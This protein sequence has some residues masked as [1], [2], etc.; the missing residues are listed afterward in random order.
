VGGNDI[1][2]LTFTDNT[3]PI[4]YGDAGTMTGHAT[5]G[6]DTITAE[7]S[8]S[9][10]V[11]T[12]GDAESMSDDT[13]G[14]G[15]TIRIDGIF[16]SDTYGD[17]GQMSGNARGG[18]DKITVEVS[19]HAL[20]SGDGGVLSGNARGGDDTITILSTTGQGGEVDDPSGAT[21]VY[22]D[23]VTMTGQTQGGKDRLIGGHGDEDFW[24]D[25]AIKAATAI[26]GRDTFVFGA[27]SGHD[28]VHDFQ[29]GKDHIE[30]GGIAADSFDELS[31]TEMLIDGKS[32]SVIDLG[33][34]SDVTVFGAM[35][36]G[37]SDFWFV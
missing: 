15:D 9:I 31:I 19:E 20:I 32:A 27:D 14:G 30:I 17:A 13:R 2:T 7:T 29:P 18:K 24:G 34:G 5:G 26:G 10:D 35:T 21:L 22:G 3:A 4:L 23:A 33:G 36:L 8:G 37:A 16:G 11:T 28:R 1:V 6:H 12:Y 25:A